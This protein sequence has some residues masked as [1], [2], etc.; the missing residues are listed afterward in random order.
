M[1][2]EPLVASPRRASPEVRVPIDEPTPVEV[3]AALS[4]I[5]SAKTGIAETNQQEAQAEVC[6]VSSSH[7]ATAGRAPLSHHDGSLEILRKICCR[8][9]LVVRQ[10]R[11]RRDDRPT[12]EVEDEYDV[13]DLLYALLRLEFEDIATEDWCPR[14]AAGAGRTDYLLQNG[15]IVIIAKKTRTGLTVRDLMDQIKIDFSHYSGRADCRTVLCFVYDPEG[16]IGNPRRLESDL[17]TV[18]NTHT[19]EVDIAPK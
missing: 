16:R 11:L 15:S 4:T 6:P 10:L 17:A 8:F 14:Y 18:C 13:Q 2:S 7:I 9:H 19:L 1:A 3:P 12:L 5:E